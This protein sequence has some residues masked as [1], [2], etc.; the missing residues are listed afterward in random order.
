MR[1]SRA[2]GNERDKAEAQV[3]A[4]RSALPMFQAIAYMVL[5]ISIPIVLVLSGYSFGALFQLSFG[6]FTIHFLTFF[7]ELSRWLD[8][9]LLAG[10]YMN[11]GVGAVATRMMPWTDHGAA[12]WMSDFVL[13]GTLIAMPMLFLAFMAWAG[14]QIN[15]ALTLGT[16]AG[17]MGGIGAASGI[18]FGKE[19]GG[20][21]DAANR[22][23]GA[24]VRAGA[25][26]A[27]RHPK[28]RA[29]R[30][31]AQAIKNR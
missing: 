16:A 21:A 28:V 26:A 14:M 25:R 15:S 6:M 24:A 13:W 30:A 29:A 1:R 7:W 20:A 27:S 3:Q 22:A 18:G 23:G 5:V 11:Q 4:M 12:Y 9:K 31:A 8:S 19:V 17:M 2:L 10:L